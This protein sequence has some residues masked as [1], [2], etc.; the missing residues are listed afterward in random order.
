M[1]IS[2]FMVDHPKKG[3]IAIKVSNPY[4]D[5]VLKVYEV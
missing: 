5:G 2:P 3:K 4:G 1:G